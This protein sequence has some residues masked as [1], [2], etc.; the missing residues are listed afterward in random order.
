MAKSKITGTLLLAEVLPEKNGILM[1]I[2]TKDGGIVKAKSTTDEPWLRLRPGM[3]AEEELQK[4]CD[5]LNGLQ[6][7][8]GQKI[9]IKDFVPK[10]ITIEKE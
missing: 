4:V 5:A 6:E 8:N 1:K 7:I 3:N 10:E 9:P 2:S